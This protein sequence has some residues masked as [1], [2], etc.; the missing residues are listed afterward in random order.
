MGYLTAVGISLITFMIIGL[1]TASFLNGPAP[2]TV[3]SNSI[4]LINNVHDW[5]TLVPLLIA[6]AF[7][8]YIW[9]AI[10]VKRLHDLGKTGWW[11]IPIFILSFIV[12][13]VFWW[14]IELGMNE[15]VYEANQYGPDPLLESHK[16]T[17]Q[18]MSDWAI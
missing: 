4:Q 10:S 5:F 11:I 8:A 1:T 15:G 3:A 7:T 14:I 2:L 17:D 12:I 13:G 18:R 16:G 6:S 9:F